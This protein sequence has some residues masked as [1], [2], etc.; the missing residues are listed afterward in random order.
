MLEKKIILITF[1]QISSNK[2]CSDLRRVLRLNKKP[3]QNGYNLF[4]QTKWYS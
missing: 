2:I 4:S 1:S 3:K